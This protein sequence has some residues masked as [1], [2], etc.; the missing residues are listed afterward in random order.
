MV[1]LLA[2]GAGNKYRGR[3]RLAIGDAGLHHG[4]AEALRKMRTKI[5][6]SPSHQDTKG[7]ITGR[8]GR[9]GRRVRRKGLGVR[10]AAALLPS[11]VIYH[12]SSAIL[13]GGPGR[14]GRKD[15]HHQ[16][17]KGTKGKRCKAE[18]QR[19]RR[20]EGNGLWIIRP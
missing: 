18:A 4:D 15:S 13:T 6:S 1:I 11:S 19:S 2:R 17:T 14:K 10:R 16:G 9:K 3:L 7:R 8:T 12:L 5:F 20:K